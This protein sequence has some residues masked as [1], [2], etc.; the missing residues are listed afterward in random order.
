MNEQMKSDIDKSTTSI[1]AIKAAAR[2]THLAQYG[3]E[4][5]TFIDGL[6]DLSF[7]IS[8]LMPMLEDAPPAVQLMAAG[9]L[10]DLCAEISSFRGAGLIEDITPELFDKYPKA[11]HAVSDAMIKQM[12]GDADAAM[13]RLIVPSH[14]H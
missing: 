14:L 2:A 7:R 8:V 10:A 13:S 3:E 6:V 1:Q 5:S 11:A 9:V 4:A 12:R